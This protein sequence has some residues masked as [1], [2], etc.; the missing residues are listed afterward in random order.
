MDLNEPAEVQWSSVHQGM[1][2]TLFLM[3]YGIITIG[4]DMICVKELLV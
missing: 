2:L 1:Y 4:D 3:G